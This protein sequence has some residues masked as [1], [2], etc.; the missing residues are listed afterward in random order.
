MRGRTVAL[1]DAT[2]KTREAD[3]EQDEKG[4]TALTRYYE[5]VCAGGLSHTHARTYARLFHF[6]S[7]QRASFFARAE[8]A[9]SAF[10]AR[11]RGSV[12]RHKGRINYFSRNAGRLR[13]M[14]RSSA[15]DLPG[16]S[17][18]AFVSINV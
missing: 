14:R 5:Q 3:G 1:R 17:G 12:P 18:V 16:A 9:R 6:H 13:T 2:R 11:G 10:T 7:P 15:R 4:E 8:S